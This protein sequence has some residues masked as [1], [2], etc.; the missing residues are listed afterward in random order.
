M[1]ARLELFLDSV[2]INETEINI[3]SYPSEVGFERRCEIREQ[4]LKSEIENLKNTFK[5]NIEGSR[6][7]EI[8]VVICSK[9]NFFKSWQPEKEIIVK[10]E[11][12]K[13]E[14]VKPLIDIEEAQRLLDKG[15]SAKIVG[16]KFG[17]SHHTIHKYLRQSALATGAA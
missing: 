17:V 6:S 5:K 10:A 11:R 8:V 13:R 1:K 3:P 14:I 9:M 12:K 7:Y 15:Y 16:K 2:L 4:Y